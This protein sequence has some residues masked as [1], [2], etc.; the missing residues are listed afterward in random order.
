MLRVEGRPCFAPASRSSLGSS[1]Y[2]P[3]NAPIALTQ[4]AHRHRH[5]AGGR[6]VVTPSRKRCTVTLPTDQPKKPDQPWEPPKQPERPKQPD[7]PW[8][9]P[10]PP[11]PSAST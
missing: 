7:Q 10:K 2:C 3:E 5:A 11:E 4:H 8:Q 1:R 6:L 9:P